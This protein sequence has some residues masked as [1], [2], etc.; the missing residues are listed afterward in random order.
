MP[1]SKVTSSWNHPFF[2]ENHYSSKPQIS[3]HRVDFPPASFGSHHLLTDPGRATLL[4]QAVKN[5]RKSLRNH[6]F[7]HD[8]C[9][10]KSN[11]NLTNMNKPGFLLIFT[12]ENPWDMKAQGVFTHENPPMGINA[13]NRRFSLLM[14]WTNILSLEYCGSQRSLEQSCAHFVLFTVLGIAI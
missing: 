10:S 11:Q 2:V 6:G 4:K 13:V 9:P 5:R 7:L 14:G 1:L 12:H 3:E 8:F